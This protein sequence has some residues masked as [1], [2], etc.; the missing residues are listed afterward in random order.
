MNFAVRDGKFDVVIVAGPQV[1]TWPSIGV[2][3]LSAF[4]SEMGLTVGQFGGESLKVKGVIP[5][6]GTG[7][8]VLVEDA[9]LRIHRIRARAVIR[10]VPESCFPDPFPGWRSQGLIP[11][12]TAERLRP[13]AGFSGIH[14]PS[15]SAP[16]IVPSDS[17]VISWSPGSLKF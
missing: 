15:F 13:R 6:P 7:G 11:I 12:R 4:C 14:S 1:E 2:R 16:E 9:Q 17:E 10:V 8:L 3:T 5:L